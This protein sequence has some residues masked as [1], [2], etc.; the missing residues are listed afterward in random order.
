MTYFGGRYITKWEDYLRDLPWDEVLVAAE[1]HLCKALCMYR[2]CP[3]DCPFKQNDN[4]SRIHVN[5]Q[6]R[7]QVQRDYRKPIL[8]FREREHCNGDCKNQ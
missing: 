2:E 6:K 8:I 3:H 4:L 1:C 7:L 5:F